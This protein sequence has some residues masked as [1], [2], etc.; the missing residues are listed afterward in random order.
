MSKT[1]TS[2][3]A[4]HTQIKNVKED[5]ITIGVPREQIFVDDEKNQVKVMIADVTEPE[6]EEILTRHDAISTTVTTH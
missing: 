5:L 4:S 3:Y 1:V 2:T 6:I